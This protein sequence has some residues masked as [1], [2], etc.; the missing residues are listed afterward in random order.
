MTAT[1]RYLQFSIF[2]FTLC[3][4]Y[5]HQTNAQSKYILRG[6]II[7]ETNLTL[8]GATV[9]LSG[10]KI[11][12]AS[13]EKG[14]FIIS[15]LLPG[16]YQLVVRMIGYN[17]YSTTVN[18]T[19]QNINLAIKVIPS[20]TELNEIV[21]T[22]NKEW[23]NNLEIFKRQF[24][25]ETPNSEKCKILNAEVLSLDFDK[26]SNILKGIAKEPLIIENQGLGYKIT[27]YLRT[28]SFDHKHGSVIFEGY[29]SFE[30]LQGTPADVERWNNN[31][32]I[33]YKGSLHNLIHAIY[34]NNLK[35]EGFEIHKIYNRAP[36]E[37]IYKS[38]VNYTSSP[39][40]ASAL[41]RT[42]DLH[43]SIFSTDGL[44]VIYK[45]EDESSEYTLKNF[46]ISNAFKGEDI[47][48]G[49]ISIVNL[50][51][52][53]IIDNQGS[54]NPT[55]NLFTEG[56]MGWERLGDQLPLDYLQED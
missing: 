49:Q 2:I 30:E 27:Y 26:V 10:T 40:V 38:S 56:Y 37:T 51:G 35:G 31:R 47:T 36:L 28:F 43:T 46:S 55:N 44:F 41:T 1:K 39:L 9:I 11:N 32:R 7:D 13:N 24:L 15:D 54:F 22:P 20:S 19:N 16:T 12:T 6:N 4:V 34:T 33:A 52:P 8:P 14:N 18:I 45:K 21:I 3:F 48:N 25:G 17:L 23:F 50:L 53:V 5:C 42:V 29:P